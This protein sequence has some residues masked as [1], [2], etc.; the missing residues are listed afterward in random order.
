MARFKPQSLEENFMKQVFFHS[1][2]W[3]W[4]GNLYYYVKIKLC[5]EI[6]MPLQKNFDSKNMELFS[7]NKINII[8]LLYI[9][10]ERDRKE[11]ER[12]RMKNR[13]RHKE[14]RQKGR[15]RERKKDQKIETKNK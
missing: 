3:P 9:K 8:A 1:A 15:K 2:S 12:E 7:R 6:C 13:K 11:R 14:E 4:H 10:K 5:A